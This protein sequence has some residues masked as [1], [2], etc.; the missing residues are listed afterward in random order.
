MAD[1]RKNWLQQEQEE[2]RKILQKFW[3]MRVQMPNRNENSIK[4]IK[5]MFLVGVPPKGMDREEWTN[6]LNNIWLDSSTFENFDTFWKLFEH[7]PS[8]K[9][10]GIAENLIQPRQAIEIKKIT[11]DNLDDINQYTHDKNLSISVL[12]GSVKKNNIESVCSENKKISDIYS[13][14]SI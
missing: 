4:N 12:L 10:V 2:N 8:L 11:N 14:H 6:K 9:A 13:M 7:V 1:S 3:D 5:D